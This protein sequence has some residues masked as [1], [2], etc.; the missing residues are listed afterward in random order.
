MMLSDSLVTVDASE[1]FH[2]VVSCCCRL[3]FPIFVA[4]YLLNMYVSSS[5]MKGVALLSSLE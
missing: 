5:G 1:F 2:T 3:V 4:F